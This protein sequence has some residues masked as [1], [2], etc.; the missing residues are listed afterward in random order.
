MGVFDFI[1]DTGSKILKGSRDEKIEAAR[2]A[3]ST[4]KAKARAQADD[5][6]ITAKARE[7][8]ER[9]REA[10]A[11]ARE[12]AAEQA[13]EAREKAAELK[14]AADERRAKARA[15]FLERRAEARKAD[16]LEEYL[17]ALGMRGDI[18]VRFDDGVVYLEGSVP[19][20]ETLERVV[21]AVGNVDGVE[22]VDEDLDVEQPADAA[23]M[24]TVQSGDT[25]SGIAQQ[26]YGDGNRY[27]EI[28]EANRPMLT[29]PNMIYPGQVLR[30]P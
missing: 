21:L 23:K 29:D 8:A 26:F 27:N 4:A 3:A 18:D 13:A 6:G 14:D 24:Y 10:A 7:A 17:D 30:I 15:A 20:Q 5:S 9:A 1:K 16:E 12:K 2:E 22:K 11:E 28:F 19:D 25:L